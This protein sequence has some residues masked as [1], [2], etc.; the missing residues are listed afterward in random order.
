MRR[1]VNL[2]QV[3]I[4]KA[5]IEHGTVSRAAEV[6]WISQ[7][8][9]SKL[10]M[11]LESD[12]GLKLFDRHKGRLVPTA[13]GLRLYEEIDRIFV[14]L[15]QVES[16]IET[17]RRENQG[18]LAVGVIPALADAFIQRTTMGFLKRNPNVYCSVRPLASQWI[19]DSVQTRKLDVGIVSSRIDNPYLV[20]E[21][22][23]EQPLVCIMPLDHAL[24]KQKVI[25]PE[26]LDGMPFISFKVDSYIGQKVAA[27]FAKY[28]VK[29]NIVMTAD[30]SPTLRQFV[31]AGLGISLVHPLFIAGIEDKVVIRPFEP[32]T[33]S[34]LLLCYARD[35]RNA[36]LISEFVKETKAVATRLVEELTGNFP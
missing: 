16:A 27:I 1:A 32:A 20:T 30:A 22:L 14:G 28:N 5:L 23:Q 15:H 25:R 33:P 29:T 11:H 24:A 3:E 12:T 18:Q 8:A 31:A 7:P 26:H 34:D 36:Q 35:A 21:H 6:M 19:V 13:L 17:V 9:A 10:L 4:F 2:R